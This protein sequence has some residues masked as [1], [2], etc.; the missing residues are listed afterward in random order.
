MLNSIYI[1]MVIVR[2]Y[3]GYTVEMQEFSTKEAC[4]AARTEITQ[5]KVSITYTSCVKK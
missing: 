1:L 3:G 5:Q 4:E 2:V